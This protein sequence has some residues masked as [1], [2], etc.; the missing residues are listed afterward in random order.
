MHQYATCG[1]ADEEGGPCTPQGGHFDRRMAADD[2][3]KNLEFRV[4]QNTSI[5]YYLG[6]CT[7]VHVVVRVCKERKHCFLSLLYGMTAL[8]DLFGK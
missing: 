7:V 2:D 6:T 5:S 3:V 1:H 4:D 8:T